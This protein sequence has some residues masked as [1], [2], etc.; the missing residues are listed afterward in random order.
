MTKNKQV[1]GIIVLVVL[2]A[3]FF[4]FAT[5]TISPFTGTAYSEMAVLKDK[6]TYFSLVDNEQSGF[7]D[8][9][10]LNGESGT[11]GQT[12]QTGGKNRPFFRFYLEGNNIPSDNFIESR[13]SLVSVFEPTN[14]IFPTVFDESSQ[15]TKQD[16]AFNPLGDSIQEI[17][18][19]G[20]IWS[21]RCAWLGD[22][23][24]NKLVQMS[25]NMICEVS[26]NVNQVCNSVPLGSDCTPISH[27]YFFEGK[28]SYIL[29][30]GFL[31]NLD[32]AKE[33]LKSE[34][35]GNFYGI[36][37]EVSFRFIQEKN[38]YR[39]ENNQC[40]LITI[41]ET[42]RTINDFDTF[43]ECQSK[44]IDEEINVYR[45]E[46]N[47]CNL[48]T[49][50]EFERTSNDFDNLNS[51]E[52]NVEESQTSTRNILIVV[53]I[54]VILISLLFVLIRFRK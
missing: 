43:S 23:N 52:L 32:G 51:C 53:G 41:K 47:E 38:F 8:Q 28:V 17:E 33:K 21:Q 34:L 36:T 10:F 14:V 18:N 48:I 11:I 24:A 44:I 5:F 22:Y 16:C 50:L 12:F 42:E 40:T 9:H 7:T 39:F 19:L 37:G 13:R 1:I 46:D 31:C 2:V 4:G 20:F 35:G 3:L 26:G 30:N 27:D 45:F 54:V 6:L 29:G 15:T 25:G 49:I